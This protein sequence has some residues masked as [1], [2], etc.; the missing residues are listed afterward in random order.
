MKDQ[1]VLVAST[2][3]FGAELAGEFIFTITPAPGRSLAETK[4]LYDDALKAFDSR[5]VTDEDIARFTGAIEARLSN[6]GQ[7][8]T[9]SSPKLQP[10]RSPSCTRRYGSVVTSQE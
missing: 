1:R 2:R 5:G 10:E 8:L 9:H 3:N 6:D 4:K 7:R